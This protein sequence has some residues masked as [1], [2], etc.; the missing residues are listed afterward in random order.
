VEEQFVRLAELLKKI[1]NDIQIIVSPGNHDCVRLMEPQPI[2]D[3]K[4]A[5]PLLE[6]KNLHLIPNPA[7]VNIGAV[8]GREAFSGF[9]VLVYHGFSFPYYANNIQ[10]LMKIKAMNSPEKIMEYLLLNRHLAPSHGSVQY[11]PSEKDDHLIK[12]VPDILFSGHTHKSAVTHYNN[13]LLISSSCWE[14]MTPYQ[15]KFGNEPDHCKVPLLNLN[16]RGIK[17]LDFEEPEVK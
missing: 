1:K 12:E 11:V 7:T 8:D 6:V 4:Y 2:F 13:I 9:N 10:S 3:E 17:I 14:S 5:W 16:T 15:A